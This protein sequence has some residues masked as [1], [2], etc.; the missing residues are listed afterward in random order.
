MRSLIRIAR[1]VLLVVLFSV[2]AAKAVQPAIIFC[3]RMVLQR[4]VPVPV[5]GRAEPDEQVTVTFAGQ[6]K[7]ATA[8]ANGLSRAQLDAMP[9]TA[10]PPALSPKGICDAAT[11]KEVLGGHGGPCSGESN[12]PGLDPGRFRKGRRMGLH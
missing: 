5:W 2:D 9:A 8:G 10:Q 6:T 3:D 7:Q 1:L 12:P 4:G 11:L